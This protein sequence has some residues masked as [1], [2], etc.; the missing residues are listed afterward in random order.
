ML[1]VLFIIEKENQNHYL[2]KEKKRINRKSPVFILI[3]MENSVFAKNTALNLVSFF[4]P[5]NLH[6][7]CIFFLLNE[8]RFE[9]SVNSNINQT[10]RAFTKEGSRQMLPIRAFQLRTIVDRNK[11][12][13]ENYP[14]QSY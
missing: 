1:V 12:P 11:T 5:F 6:V 14:A 4:A 2:L 7:S 3:S 13:D 10:N 9:K 8:N